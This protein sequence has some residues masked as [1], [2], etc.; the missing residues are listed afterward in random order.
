M[1]GADS[2]EDASSLAAL[3]RDIRAAEAELACAETRALG[4]PRPDAQVLRAQTA[5]T[6][7][8]AAWRHAMAAESAAA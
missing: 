1:P 8:R 7:A 4:R 6:L 5:V 3:L 2:R